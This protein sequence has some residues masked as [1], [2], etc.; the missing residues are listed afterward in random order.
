MD[1][2]GIKVMSLAADEAMMKIHDL[3]Q[4]GGSRVLTLLSHKMILS[5]IEEARYLEFLNQSD[6]VLLC[7]ESVSALINTP[8]L[9]QEQILR[10]GPTLEELAGI[11]E[12]EQKKVLLLSQQQQTADRLRSYLRQM[13]SSLEFADNIVIEDF[14]ADSP[15]R[16]MN[17][18]N[19]S[20][21]DVLFIIGDLRLQY[22]LLGE[23]RQAM[24]SGQ[25]CVLGDTD[26]ALG[27]GRI[28]KPSLIRTLFE[29]S[30]IKRMTVAPD[31]EM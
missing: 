13:D 17:E 14:E 16:L 20:G 10:L 8:E 30:K 4:E 24:F 26:L 21:A 3:M 18:I 1:L 29:K 19:A 28:K 23:E 11:L 27:T 12:E 15:D 5:G 25:L 22:W 6:M 7:D 31:E 2:S 9:P